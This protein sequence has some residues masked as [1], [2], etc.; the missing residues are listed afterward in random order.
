MLEVYRK[1]RLYTKTMIKNVLVD[2]SRMMTTVMG[3]AGCATLLVISFTLLLAMKN[4]ERVPFEQYLLYEHRLVTDSRIT[5]GTAFEDL[6]EEK[7][8]PY[9]RVTDKLKLCRGTGG[10]W[11][12]AHVLAVGLA[13]FLVLEDPETRQILQ[14]PARGALISIRYAETL[15][16]EEGDEIEILGSDGTVRKLTVAGVIEH[17]LG[18]NLF[19]ISKDYYETVFA[20]PADDCVFLLKGDIDGLYEKASTMEGFISL[21]DNSEYAGLGDVMNIIVLICFVFAALMAVLVMLNQNVMYIEQKAKELSVM[22]INGFTMKETKAFVSRDTFILTAL[23][24]LAGWVLGIILGHW[25]ILILE[26]GVTHYVRSP[27]WEACLIAAAI[28]GVFAFAMN[29]IA[30]RRIAKLNLTNVNAN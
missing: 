6:L 23:G 4:S 17:Y 8:I 29:K 26:V 22:R 12:G 9:A 2:K 30:V 27:S 3:V 10:E 28:C 1:L 13:D 16:L 15:G 20:E 25:V 24:I 11:S 19:V 5:D 14:L 7:Q 18:F 21:R